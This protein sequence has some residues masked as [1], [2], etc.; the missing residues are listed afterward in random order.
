MDFQALYQ[1]KLTTAAEAAKLVKSGDW[2]DYTWCTNHPVEL[3]KALAARQNE[4]EDVKVRGGVTMW[5]P[6]IAKADDAGE[7][8]AWHSWHCS[9]IDRKIIAKGMGWFSP[10]RYS[11]L[12]RF[13]RENL[14]PVDVVFTQVPPMDE[15]GNF[16]FSLA[17]SHLYDMCA[18][19]KHIVV[20]V[21]K[22]LPPVYGLYKAELN[23]ADVTYVVEGNN[24]SIPELG[25]VPPT[26]VDRTVA[27]LI[28]PEI[29]NGACLQ[30]GIGGMPNTVGALIAESD[31]KDLGVH[32]EMYVD[33]FVDMSMAGRITGA[34]KPFDRGRQTYAFAA[35]TQKLYDFL[36]NNPECMAAPVS[37]VNDI[38]RVSQIDNFISIN[39]AV[40]VDL[41]GQV[42]SESS[43]TH[44]ISGAGGQQDFVM[45]AYLS[46]GGKSFIC[47]SSAYKDKKTGQLKSRI[48]P[49]LL[50]GSVVT[51]TRTNLHYVVTEY[52]KFN[53]KG[54]STWE[55]AEGLI[56]IAH[57]QFR[58]E[59]IAAAE[60]MHIWRRSNKR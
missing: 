12:P 46:K 59:L 13:Y 6:E 48:R 35:G 10:M 29:P 7:H 41:Y 38:A 9:G 43:G 27:N 49:T 47:C 1:S 36:N 17:P 15:H 44:H 5:M 23:I 37:Y 20:E 58:E 3:D 31:L 18:R 8:F 50:E 32:T 45:G 51:A 30:L 24:P 53:A 26:D 22:N 2:V 28:V 57:P 52:G 55:R 19:A 4:L 42:S 56:A 14:D 25:S 39:G 33:A 60:K 11:E 40:D 16:S 54:K 34:C 21:N